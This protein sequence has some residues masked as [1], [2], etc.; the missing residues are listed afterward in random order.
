MDCFQDVAKHC[1]FA[2][3][4]TV[5]RFVTNVYTKALKDIGLTAVQYSMLTAILML[6]RS[7]I[8]DLSSV[9]KMDRTTINRNLKPLVRDGL[10]YVDES[11]DRREKIVMITKEGEA[12]YKKGYENWKAAQEMLKETLGEPL[13]DEMHETLD[14]VIAVIAKQ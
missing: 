13:W 7:N 3:T 6:K 10:V 11:A 14:K 1:L 2:K 9:L 4:R 5:S 8:N 12:I